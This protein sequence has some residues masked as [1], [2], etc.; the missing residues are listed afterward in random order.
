VPSSVFNKFYN[1]EWYESPVLKQNETYMIT[2]NHIYLDYIPESLNGVLISGKVENKINQ[3]ITTTSQFLV[4]YNTGKI[5]FHPDLNGTNISISQYYAKGL[6]KTNAQRVSLDDV[7]G[8]IQADNVE[9]FA[10][11]V[12]T[13]YRTVQYTGEEITHVSQNVR[14]IICDEGTTLNAGS[15]PLGTIIVVK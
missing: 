11:E 3:E 14:F 8:F 1:V 9:D 4:D 6:I 12:M 10:K 5:L 13:N 7:D 2:E 15:L